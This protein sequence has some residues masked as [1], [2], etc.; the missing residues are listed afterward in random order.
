MRARIIIL[1]VFILG[2]SKKRNDDSDIL[3]KSAIDEEKHLI[4]SLS[5]YKYVVTSITDSG[6][7]RLAKYNCAL[8]DTIECKGHPYW[9]VSITMGNNLCGGPNGTIVK[10]DWG[11]FF[12]YEDGDV[13]MSF[14]VFVQAPFIDSITHEIYDFSYN[15]LWFNRHNEPNRNQYILDSLGNLSLIVKTHNTKEFYYLQPIK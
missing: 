11:N 14:P 10:F 4:D 13:S 6:G 7:N 15:A 12:T 9:S 8:D 1:L 5:T 3:Y 2:C